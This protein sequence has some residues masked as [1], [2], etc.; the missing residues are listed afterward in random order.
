MRSAE[1]DC[2]LRLSSGMAV[3][4]SAIS[5][6]TLSNDGYAADEGG[7]DMTP[8]KCAHDVC[9]C[10]VAPNGPYGKYCSEHCRETAKMTELHCG[11]R[12]PGC[13]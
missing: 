10:Q 7:I 4:Y 13:S 5:G 6:F 12:H 8:T 1:C 11:C 3:L 2:G 9:N